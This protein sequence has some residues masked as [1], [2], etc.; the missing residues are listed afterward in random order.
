M[1]TLTRYRKAIAGLI[2]PGVPLFGLAVADGS[3]SQT[4]WLGIGAACLAGFVGV[5][6]APSNASSGTD[7]DAAHP[8]QGDPPP[9]GGY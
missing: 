3:V 6:A 5:V 4:E 1:N 9:A 8:V 7:I 2:S